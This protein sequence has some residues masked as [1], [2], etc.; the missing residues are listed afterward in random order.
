MNP[1]KQHRYHS[2]E[3]TFDIYS[4]RYGPYFYPMAMYDTTKLALQEGVN[5]VWH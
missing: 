5:K 2:T 3:T 1:E 4:N